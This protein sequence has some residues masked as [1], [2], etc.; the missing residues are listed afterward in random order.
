M[1]GLGAV[2]PISIITIACTI[3]PE[4]PRWLI[5]KQRQ[6][7]ALRVGLPYPLGLVNACKSLSSPPHALPQ[8]TFPPCAPGDAAALQ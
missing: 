7:E 6:P 5:E 8:P 4:T 1:L 3:L 2:V